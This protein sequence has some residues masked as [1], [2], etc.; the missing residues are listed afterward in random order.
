MNATPKISVIIPCFNAGKYIREAI[1]SILSQT[2]KNLEILLV[3][4]GS[5]DDTKTIIE[6]YAARDSR[7]MAVFNE[8]NLGLIRTLNKSVQL[9]TGE[10]IARMDADDISVRHRIELLY[11]KFISTPDT[12]IA[13]AAYYYLTTNNRV[14]RKAYPKA[15]LSKAL[16]FVSFFSTPV[17]HPCILARS[18]VMKDNPYDENYIHSEDYELFSRLLRKNYSIVNLNEPVYYLR[19]NPASV[20]NK[21]ESIQISTHTRISVRNMEEYFGVKYD[22]FQHKV[23]INR[24]SFNVSLSLIHKSLIALNELRDEFI[25]KEKADSETISEINGFLIEQKMDIFLQAIKYATVFNKVA[26][27]CLVL[28]RSGLFLNHRAFRYFKLKFNFVGAYVK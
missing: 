9:A 7:I 12:D 1:D 2:Y 3:D 18:S 25:R 14:I 17:N 15:T 8:K 24:I 20:S 16:H 5:T 13:S 26:L 4:D 11:N 28:I 22:F 27:F 23:M 6:E 21:Y 19:I 10:F